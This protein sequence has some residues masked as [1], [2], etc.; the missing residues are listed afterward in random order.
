M[1]KH[2]KKLTPAILKKII[3]EEKDKL[4]KTRRNSKQSIKKEKKP[5][6]EAAINQLA[7]LALQEAKLLLK[8]KKIRSQRAKIKSTLKNKRG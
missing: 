8:A 6:T 2:I 1:G 5:I 4:K 3:A 7:I